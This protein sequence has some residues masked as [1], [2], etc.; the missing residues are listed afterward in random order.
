M[1]SDHQMDWVDKV[2]SHEGW[3]P[4]PDFAG[5]VVTRVMA[6]RPP[7]GERR[8]RPFGLMEL[9]RATVIGFCASML[10]R[11]EGY[12]WTLRQLSHL[13]WRGHGALR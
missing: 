4:P 1:Q 8:L 9:V 7:R 5:R 2:M 6:V 12:L 10:A 13:M 3:D 11:I